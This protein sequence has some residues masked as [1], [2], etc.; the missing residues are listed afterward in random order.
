[1]R[2][3]LLIGINDLRVFLRAK[4]SFI[5]LFV[6]PLVFIGFMGFA[7][8]GPGQPGNLRPTVQVDN[9]DTN[10]LAAVFVEELG[11]QGM[12]VL[13]PASTEEAAQKILIP[14][15]FTAH[16]LAGEQSKVRFSRKGNGISAESAMVELRLVLALIGINSHLLLAGAAG[17][18]K[19]SESAV[20]EAQR[21]APL[22]RVD[23]R[24]AGRKPA[25]SGFSFSLPGNMVMYVMMNLLIFGGVAVTRERQH[26]I[27]RRLACNPLTRGQVVGGKILGL[28]LLG[29]VQVV[30]FLLA[31]RFFFGVNLGANLPAVLLTLFVYSWV[32]A[33]LGVLVGSVIQAEDKVIGLCVMASLLM[34]CLGGCWWPLEIGPPILKTIAHCLPTGWALDA[35]HQL[36]SF[37]GGLADAGKPLAVLAAF[38][39]T[40]NVLA[41]RLF[42]WG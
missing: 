30:V 24:F 37:G 17:T 18:G 15:D 11:S 29:G 33:S 16:V 8:R 26:G 42:R 35:L 20:R 25:P 21:S 27:V 23:A 28:I 3:V 34:A 4:A 19:L 40:A 7:M 31:G 5:W 10:Y 9:R 32:A 13:G 6:V 22:V 38:G 12:R 36:I 1:M 39:A 2:T 14:S 41:A